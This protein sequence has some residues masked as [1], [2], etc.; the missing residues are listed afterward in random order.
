MGFELDR[1]QGDN[2]RN[3]NVGHPSLKRNV[4]AE[5]PSDIVINL[6]NGKAMFHTGRRGCQLGLPGCR[7]QGDLG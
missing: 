2:P 1:A 6:G 3:D 5:V 4:L 7:L